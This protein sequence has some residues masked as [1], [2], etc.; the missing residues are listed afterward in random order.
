MIRTQVKVQLAVFSVVTA[1]SVSYGAVTFLD[2]DELLSPPYEVTA[3]FAH[4]GG[5]YPRADV[6]LLGT[7]VG[8]VTEVLPGPG[9]GTT[10]V[11]AIRSDVEIPADVE[12]AIGAKSAIGEQYVALTPRSAGGEHLADGD[13]I[14]L[15]DTRSPTQVAT[16]LGN[17]EALAASVDTDDVETVLTE[18]ATALDRSGPT[19]GRLLDDSDTLTRASLDNVD[20]LTALIEDAQVVLDTQVEHGPE[21]RQWAEELAGFTETVDQID[22]QL[23]QLFAAGIV[24]GEQVS[25]LL[26]DNQRL[27]PLLLDDLLVMTAL[28]EHHLPGI[29]KVL[30]LFPWILEV[31]ASTVRYCDEIDPRTGEPIQGTC[32]YD[33]QGRPIYSAHLGA[34]LPELPGQPPYHGCSTGYDGTVKHLPDGTPVEGGPKQEP[35]SDPNLDARCT[36]SPTDPDSPSVRGAQNA[37][38]GAQ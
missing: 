31:G 30:A 25:G 32:H 33:D 7:R 21:T 38:E 8:E 24:S 17:V 18:L 27:L 15:G 26:R 2:A 19:V 1:L 11:M 37:P 35:D 4:S 34:Q 20:D 6:D 14:E 29:R 10:V 13:V 5:V 23:A 12:A 16:L 3:H 9:R 28:A 36:A 22:P